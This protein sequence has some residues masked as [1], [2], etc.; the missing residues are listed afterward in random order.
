MLPLGKRS[1]CKLNTI[2]HQ[3]YEEIQ[4]GRGSA[5][6]FGKEQIRC[7]DDGH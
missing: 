4:W 3:V 6:G 5:G 1:C 7:V 2:L